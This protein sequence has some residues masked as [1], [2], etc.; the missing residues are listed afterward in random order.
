MSRS[1]QI[2]EVE[3]RVYVYACDRCGTEMAPT[4]RFGESRPGEGSSISAR[5]YQS[6]K[7]PDWLPLVP[8]DG[9]QYALSNA[10]NSDLCPSCTASLLEWFADGKEGKP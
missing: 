7:S 1:T 10:V 2:R 5:K 9:G 8:Y 4:A 6:D 3:Q